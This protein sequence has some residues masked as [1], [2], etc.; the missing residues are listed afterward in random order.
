MERAISYLNVMPDTKSGIQLFVEK[1]LSEVE[2]RQALPLLVKLTAMEKIIEGVKDGLKEQLLDEA[3]LEG[4]KT[5]SVNG[6]R[7]E[8]KSK[9]TYHYNHCA[10]HEEMKAQLKSLE[11]MMKAAKMPFADTETGEIIEPAR[12]SFTDY[13]AVTLNKE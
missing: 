7:F 8:K 2:S 12:T 5:F 6:V 1:V 11:D 10:K 13:L 9:T 3:S 4:E